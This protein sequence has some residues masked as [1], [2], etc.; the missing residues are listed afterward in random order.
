MGTINRVLQQEEIS[1]LSEVLARGG[2]QNPCLPLSVGW[3]MAR[4]NPPPEDIEAP[5]KAWRVEE[6][7]AAGLNCPHCNV[8][9]TNDHYRH[10][11]AEPAVRAAR[12]A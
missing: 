4:R 5:I 3:A 2:V 9:Y 10:F 1:S 11:Y 7:L 12:K 6:N 8:P